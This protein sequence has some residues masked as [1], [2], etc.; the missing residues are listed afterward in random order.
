MLFSEWSALKSSLGEKKRRLF[1]ENNNFPVWNVHI[2]NDL[3][4]SGQVTL[5][6]PSEAL[7]NFALLESSV[8][9][10]PLYGKGSRSKPL[11]K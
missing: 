11:R 1:K 5:L 3:G 4:F 8:N 7:S 2:S 9:A 10:S 6:R